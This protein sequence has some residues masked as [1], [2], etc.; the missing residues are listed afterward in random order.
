MAI[1]IERKFLVVGEAWRD[2]VEDETRLVQGY[3]TEDAHITVRVRIRGDTA[4]LSLKG[5]TQGI[6]RLEFEYPI[7][8]DDAETLLRELAVSPLIEK[9]RYR[10]RHAGHLWE[11]DVFAGANAGLVLAELELKDLDET[12]VRPDWLGAEVSN[13]PRYFNVNLARHPY[14]DWS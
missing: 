12:F 6:C 14:C 3:L 8:I 9:T 11:L 7:P 10:V 2:Q 1:E 4:W 5:K 13:D